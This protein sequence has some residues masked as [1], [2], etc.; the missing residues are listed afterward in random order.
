MFVEYNFFKIH[1]HGSFG[2]DTKLSEILGKNFDLSDKSLRSEMTLKDLLSH[3]TGLSE[4]DIY[5][6]VPKIGRAEY[7]KLVV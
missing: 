6:G 5:T 3:R 7:V 2:W 1:F 4:G